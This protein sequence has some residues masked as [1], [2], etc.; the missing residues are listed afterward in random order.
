MFIWFQ[1]RHWS[2]FY[3]FW[4]TLIIFVDALNLLIVFFGVPPANLQSS[5]GFMTPYK[6]IMWSKKAVQNFW[7]NF[8]WCLPFS[9]INLL[10][11]PKNQH[12]LHFYQ[13]HESKKIFAFT[14]NFHSSVKA[15]LKKRNRWVLKESIKAVIL[16]GIIMFSDKMMFVPL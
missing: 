4:W 1:F 14:S 11:V 7:W 8:L 9:I 5:Y 13:L 16:K 10:F 12:R 6:Y 2:E 15:N 3:T